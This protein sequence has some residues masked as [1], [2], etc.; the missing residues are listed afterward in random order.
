[1]NAAT[2]GRP[3][4]PDKSKDRKLPATHE[5]ARKDKRINLNFPFRNLNRVPTDLSATSTSSVFWRV[6]ES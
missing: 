3:P 6:I 5:A 4:G 2:T 1:M